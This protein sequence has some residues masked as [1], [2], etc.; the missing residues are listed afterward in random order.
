MMNFQVKFCPPSKLR[1]WRTG[2]LLETKSKG[3]AES[4][5][6]FLNLSEVSQLHKDKVCWSE[7]LQFLV[8]QFKCE[9]DS[10]I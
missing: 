6:L 7:T 10:R 5:K 9:T 3:H 1:L 8:Q 2:M 4:H